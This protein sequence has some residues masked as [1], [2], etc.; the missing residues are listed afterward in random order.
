MFIYYHVPVFL[1]SLAFS[2]FFLLSHPLLFYLYCP[3]LFFFLPPTIPQSL[4]EQAQSYIS[5]VDQIFQAHMDSTD[6]HKSWAFWSAHAGFF[7]VRVVRRKSAMK[8]VYK[9]PL[10]YLQFHAKSLFLTYLSK[11][12]TSASTVFPILFPVPFMLIQLNMC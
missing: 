10:F 3:C 12:S 8:P 9:I 6:R 5:V 7:R 4:P 11:V 2:L 1:L